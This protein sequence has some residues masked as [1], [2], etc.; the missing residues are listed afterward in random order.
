[1]PPYCSDPS[2]NCKCCRKLSK[3]STGGDLKCCR[4]EK[5]LVCWKTFWF[6]GKKFWFVGKIFRFV[7]KVLPL[8]PP[9]FPCWYI[10]LYQHEWKLEKRLFRTSRWCW[11][12]FL[13]LIQILLGKGFQQWKFATEFCENY[14][15]NT[16]CNFPSIFTRACPPV[17]QSVFFPW[18]H[19]PE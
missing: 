7:G 12:L 1:M 11:L 10:Q 8:A 9:H 17:S 2:E 5:C 6:V 14:S 15:I 16:E 3:L 18:H 4:P 13:A 19:F